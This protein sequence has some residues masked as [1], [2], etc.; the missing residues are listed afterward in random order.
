MIKKILIVVAMLTL[1]FVAVD[2]ASANG[3]YAARQR[4]RVVRVERVQQHHYYAP[5]VRVQRV[6]RVERVVYPQSYVR[7]QRVV[8]VPHYAVETVVDDCNDC[9]AQQNV[10]VERVV[11]D[12]Y[13]HRQLIRS[14]QRVVGG[15]SVSVEVRR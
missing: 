4:Q 8:E 9:Y 14:R 3:G 10:V 6:V 1:A 15:R 11:V 5:A 12:R 7:V 2:T 13:G